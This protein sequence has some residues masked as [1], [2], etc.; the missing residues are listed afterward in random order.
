MP[1]TTSGR[2]LGWHHP[3]LRGKLH[4]GLAHFATID[5]ATLPDEVMLGALPPVLDQGQVGSCTANAIAGAVSILYAHQGLAPMVP[6]R[7]SI[8]YR[9]RAVEGTVDTDAGA[10]LADGIGVVR[11]GYAPE[12]RYVPSWGPEWMDPPAPLAPD[13]PRVVN[14]D[15]LPVSVDAVM[16]C[17]ASGFPVVVGLSITDAWE[18]TPGDTLPMPGGDPIGGH[19]L[20]VVGY[21]KAGTSVLLRIRNSWGEGWMDGGYAWAPGE[22]ISLATCGEVHVLRATR[23]AVTP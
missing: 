19:A 22:W 21:K 6:D 3:A 15:P 16:W 4:A 7:M 13:A 11:E 23:A 12:A 17:L 1:R 10:M 9:E 5:R 18:S 14:S 2:P 8:Y 20:C